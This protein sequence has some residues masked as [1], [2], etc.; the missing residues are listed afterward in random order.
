MFSR[1]AKITATVVPLA[2]F[3]FL[4]SACG[5]NSG[6]DNN[7]SP[8]APSA[9]PS[10]AA[11]EP[12]SPAAESETASPPAVRAYTDAAGRTVDIPTAPQR[13]VAHYYAA[14]IAALGIPM[15]GTNYLNAQL[16]LTDAQLQGVEDIGGTSL[17]PNLEKMLALTP[18][19][20]IIPDFLEQTDIDALSKIAPTVVI[21]YGADVFTRLRALADIVGQPDTAEKWIQTYEQKAKEKRALV[22]SR[23]SEGETASAFILYAADKQLYVYNKQ[24]LGPTMYDAF[25]FSIPPKVT[26]LF[27]G[28]PDSLWKTISLE[29][30]SDYAGDRLFFI[31]SDDSE[32][33]KKAIEEVVNGP[34]WKSLPAVKNGKAYIVDKRWSMNDP[35]TLDW[36][37]DEMA[38][39]LAK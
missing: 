12:A 25:G 18:D 9:S 1:L 29:T 36:L 37:L 35:L 14:E 8:S 4:L 38:E 27:E 26:E 33:S 13:I 11:T 20:I 5:G 39:L 22:Q 15:V 28:E 34:V 16:V 3:I 23:I 19:L 10:T 30:L 7:A 21:S 17:A 31:A 6:S 32:E 24:R 2:L